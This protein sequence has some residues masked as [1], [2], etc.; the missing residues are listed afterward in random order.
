MRPLVSTYDKVSLSLSLS[1]LPYVLLCYAVLCCVLYCGQCFCAFSPCVMCHGLTSNQTDLHQ[2]QQ[3]QQR[4]QE[5][6][7][8]IL[9]W[10]I[11]RENRTINGV[12]GGRWR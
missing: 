10:K 6:K 9:R 11:V 4:R 7:K 5:R 3:R 8:N 2:V 12:G 1:G